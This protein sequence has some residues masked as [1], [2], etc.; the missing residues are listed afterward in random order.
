MNCTI[1][2][3][4]NYNC[5]LC[6]EKLC[7]ITGIKLRMERVAL[8]EGHSSRRV[9]LE[10]GLPKDYCSKSLLSGIGLSSLSEIHSNMS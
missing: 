10:E 5:R 4:C 7:R 9:V 3:S 2:S 1:L 8:E 6:P